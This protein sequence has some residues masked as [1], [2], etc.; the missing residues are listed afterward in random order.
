MEHL[1]T[2]SGAWEVFYRAVTVQCT[3]N[4]VFISHVNCTIHSE[5]SH[6]T[7][8][9]IIMHD[10]LHV[11]IAM[12][13]LHCMMD[14]FHTV[15]VFVSLESICQKIH[16]RKHMAYYSL[17]TAHWHTARCT[18]HTASCTMHSA[19]W[20]TPDSVIS[21]FLPLPTWGRGAS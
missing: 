17:H 19:V 16:C 11:H 4:L 20:L 14:T 7:P 15:F 21:G 6:C 3:L 5:L 8:C 1:L 13:R 10:L 9:T 2:G 12:Q 18:V